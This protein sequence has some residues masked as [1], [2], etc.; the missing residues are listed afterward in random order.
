MDRKIEK[1]T[2]TTKRIT[3]LALGSLFLLFLIYNIGFG[4]YGSRLNVEKEKLSISTVYRGDFQEFIVVT[5]TVMPIK[6]VYLDAIEGGQ[7]DTI[8][9]EAGTLLKAGDPILRLEN[10]SLLIQISNQD[11][12]VV[13]QRNLLTNTRFNLDQNRTRGRELLINREYEI[14]RLQRIY[15]RQKEL[16]EANLI[17]KDD[18]LQAKDDFE[19]EVRRQK[20]N[21][22]AF[23]RD[24]IFQDV[25]L[26][27]L[28]SSL[29]RLDDN[30][31]IAQKRL[32]N[33]TIRAPIGGQLTSLN[34]E[35]GESKSQGER[36]GQLDVLDGF[37][38]RVAVDEHYIARIGIG[39]SGAFDFAGETYQM[40]TR[41]IYPEV[42]N[43]RF[44]V[45]MEFDG[46]EPE[47]IRRGQTARVRLELGDL[48]EAVMLDRGGFFQ[49]TGGNWVY[50][51]DPSGEVATKR[52]IRL[53]RQNTQVF[54]VL[55][56]LQP[57]E[58]VI[59]SSYDNYGDIDKLVIKD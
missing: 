21:L 50:V 40:T 44:E 39:Q 32:E 46:E 26:K 30:L 27:Q 24:S 41:K 5:G 19:F 9:C 57:G 53:G 12:Q 7:V 54:E 4:D 55:E 10:T 20:L 33:L 45:D 31:R 2:W 6:T 34:A 28:E 18:Y 35:I 37:K 14:R 8:Y 47:G 43:G 15:E 17:S 51:V 59:T 36:I 23:K 38:V 29:D 58:K 52:N 25:Q 1:K 56:G 22:E 11:A 3:Y 16:H 42:T 49:K 13:E 48:S